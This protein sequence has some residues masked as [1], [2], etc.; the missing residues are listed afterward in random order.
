MSKIALEAEAAMFHRDK[1]NELRR[2]TPKPTTTVQ[3]T[4]IAAVD[5]S[6]AQMAAAII[7]LTTTGR[8]VI[9][10][11]TPSLNSKHSYMYILL[12]VQPSSL[13]NS[14]FSVTFIDGLLITFTAATT[15]GL[16]IYK[17]LYV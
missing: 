13:W 2:L 16:C 1:F 5:A 8:C 15:L 10:F 7:T 14:D 6:F 9:R 12:G 17:L 11:F 3:T 4:S